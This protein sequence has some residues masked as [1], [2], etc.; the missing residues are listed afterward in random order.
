MPFGPYPDPQG[1][2]HIS[3]MQ[4]AVLPQEMSDVLQQ[5]GGIPQEALD[6]R[7]AEIVQKLGK[8]RDR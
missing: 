2:A 3:G 5:Q 1:P 8:A 6:E 4:A 7:I